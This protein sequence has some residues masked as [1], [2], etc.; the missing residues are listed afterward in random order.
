MRKLMVLPLLA[1]LSGCVSYYYPEVALEDGVY[2]AEDDPSYTVYADGYVG[3]GYYPW[4]SLDYFYTGYYPYSS[5]RLTYG[6]PSGLSFGNGYGFSPWYYPRH[7]YG[8]YSP[9]HVSYSHHYYPAWQ[10]YRGYSSHYYGDRHWKKRYYDRYGHDR[11]ASHHRY[12]RHDRYNRNDRYGRD[13]RYNRSDRYSRS[14]RYD[15][16]YDRYRDGHSS[17]RP[18][19][20][21]ERYRDSTSVR[22]YVSTPPAG[23]SGDRG[24]VVRNRGQAKVGESRLENGRQPAASATRQKVVTPRSRQP[25]NSTRRSSGEVRYRADRKQTPSR[26]TPVKPST[27]SVD[28]R[29]APPTSS[30]RRDAGEVRYRSK[31]KQTKSR[32]EPVDS[33]S[34]SRRLSTRTAQGSRARVVAHD[35]AQASGSVAVRPSA[36]TRATSTSGKS[37]RSRPASK[38]GSSGK[39]VSRNSSSSSQESSGNKSNSR[40]KNHR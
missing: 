25:V 26:T 28:V 23:R 8:Y 22:R 3:G 38:S 32:V 9:W 29:V 7:Y 16:R 1:L 33:G 10:P 39:K 27:R 17:Q 4:Y 37:P 18:G 30:T 12:D 31:S 24:V 11:Y 36:P 40:R 2:Y 20:E 6:Y 34:P 5:Y 35:N 13:D 19:R 14:D 21:Q 15:N